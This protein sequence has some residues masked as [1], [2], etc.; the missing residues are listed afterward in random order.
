MLNRSVVIP[1]FN[2]AQRLPAL[3]RSLAEHVDPATTEVIVVDDG[4]QDDTAAVATAEAAWAPHLVV[5]R[6]PENRGKGAA[7][8]AGVGRSTAPIVT[9]VDAD[10]ATDLSALAPM[11]AALDQAHAAFGSRNAPGAQVHGS[12]PLRGFM[13]RTFSRI[14]RAILGTSISDSQ[15]GAKTFRGDLARQLFNSSTL[16]GFAFDV[17]ILRLLELHGLTVVEVPVNWTHQA[18]S[19]IGLFDPLRMLL[20]TIRVRLT[21]KPAP[22]PEELQR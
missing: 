17:E 13:G 4:S 3:L 12:P 11:E 19:K 21:L 6:L 8:R 2:E 22:L 18:G 10:N 7:V 5:L 20:D 14:A 1:A 15:C 16:D 9:F